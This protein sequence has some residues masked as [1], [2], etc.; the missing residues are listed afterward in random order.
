MKTI[1][2]IAD[3]VGVDKQRVDR[4]FKKHGIKPHCQDGQKHF[5][6]E[7]AVEVA[8]S[9]FAKSPHHQSGSRTASSTQNT[10]L[11]DTVLKQL[12]SKDRQIEF[13]LAENR[14]LRQLA[15]PAADATTNAPK[16]GRWSRLKAAWKGN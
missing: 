5:Y 3:E 13:L 4:L 6:G 2:Q 8:V 9:H 14:E 11:F 1:K 7:S 15:L 10:V 12:E 16:Q